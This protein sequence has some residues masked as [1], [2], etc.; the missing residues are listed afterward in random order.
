[1][2]GM[3]DRSRSTASMSTRA[4][5]ANKR[6]LEDQAGSTPSMNKKKAASSQA[7]S[8][9]KGLGD[10]PTSQSSS[11][12]TFSKEIQGESGKEPP[13]SPEKERG[14]HP[15]DTKTLNNHVA[16]IMNKLN[17]IEGNT[18]TLNTKVSSLFSK[19]EDQSTRLKGAESSLATHSQQIKELRKNQTSLVLEVNEKV[20]DQMQA[21][22]DSL[23][24]DNELFRAELIN[25]MNKKVDKATSALQEDFREEKAV[26]REKHKRLEQANGVLR[27]E[28]NEEK[29]I[30]REK[31][32]IIM[33]LQ[34]AGEGSTDRDLAKTL[35]KD[36]LGISNVDIES[37]YRLGRPGG[38]GPRPLMIK[39]LR[40]P[41]R[42]RV[43]FSKSKLKNGQTRKIWLQ[44]DL[45]K[46]I[47]SAQRNLY[48]AFKKAKSMPDTFTTVQLKGTKLILNGTAYGDDNMDAL[49]AALQPSSMAT[50]HSESVVVF[51][52]RASPLSNHH[53]STFQLEG[54][55][56]NS[57]EQF[58]AWK[59]ARIS[60]KKGLINRA[61]SST[62]PVVC[63]GILNELKDDNVP[64][65]E[66]VLEEVVNSGLTAKFGQNENLAQFLI[67]THPKTLGEA[68]LNKRWGIGLPLNSPDVFDTSK[69]V[70]G[71]NLLGKKLAQ[72][73]DFLRT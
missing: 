42:N 48:Q 36:S 67:D 4:K 61:L 66:E 53:Y 69:W 19:L 39:F 10:T 49:P 59:R 25:V 26:S 70:E 68:S 27:E 55:S 54:H 21:F 63:K 50:L 34:E 18:S 15:V 73:R 1:M 17:S 37:I 51:F 35:F 24:K 11:P 22:K 62:N 20:E 5:E 32:L 13:R 45:P 43:W 38:T 60:G 9:T 6:G 33:G 28:F 30:S 47:K 31:N 44:E 7:N 40:M 29:A 72:V 56:F 46:P 23:N 3:P 71:G 16:L 12:V 14:S 52:G 58:L 41:D 2:M 57:M 8:A 65:W 64:K